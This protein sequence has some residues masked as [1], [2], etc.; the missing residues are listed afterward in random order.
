MKT[1]PMTNADLVFRWGRALDRKHKRK[2]VN[3][4]VIHLE[5]PS[6]DCLSVIYSGRGW[7][8]VRT[9]PEQEEL[10]RLLAEHD[11]IIMLGHGSP[12]GLFG[13][14]T[15]YSAFA[16]G[17]REAHLLRNKSNIYIWCYASS[18]VQK[19]GLAGFA[20]GMFI[21]EVGEAH[22]MGVKTTSSQVFESNRVFSESVGRHVDDPQVCQ[23]VIKDYGAVDSDV[24]R[25]NLARL[26]Q[27][28]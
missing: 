8:V 6:T 22:V 28:S 17:E 11:R 23:K 16:I 13:S 18:Y 2:P 12:T 26:Q 21:S 14:H 3:T 5:D 7:K 4:L 20:S 10:E 27:F 19:H 9:Q 15:S 24:A 25:Y 1:L